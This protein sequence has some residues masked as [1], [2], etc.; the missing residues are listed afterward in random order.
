MGECVQTEGKQHCDCPLY[1]WPLTVAALSDHQGS[2]SN[3][4]NAMLYPILDSEARKKGISRKTN[5]IQI[6]V[7]SLP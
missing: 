2:F 3:T 1:Q 6:T 7:T 5:E 4:L